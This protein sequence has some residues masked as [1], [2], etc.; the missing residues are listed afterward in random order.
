MIEW[1]C[2]AYSGV[3]LCH[4]RTYSLDAFASA[5]TPKRTPAK[6]ETKEVVL[7]PLKTPPRTLTSEERIDTNQ[8][9]KLTH[10]LLH[11][12]FSATGDLRMQAFVTGSTA[13]HRWRYADEAWKTRGHPHD[14]DVAVVA[15]VPPP[16]DVKTI[17]DP[18]LVITEFAR[19]TKLACDGAG[20][21]LKLTQ[22][23]KR[24]SRFIQCKA[25]CKLPAEHR[26]LKTHGDRWSFMLLS[27]PEPRSGG[28]DALLHYLEPQ[29]LHVAY[30]SK[31]LRASSRCPILSVA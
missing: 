2:C 20:G 13:L 6:D 31:I 15:M 21:E 7:A 5:L 10:E 24:R 25:V 3:C 23:L 1:W 16:L 19:R 4:V 9:L 17:A 22:Y 12:C 26:F 18:A 8:R 29:F 28:T 11:R 30:G 27:S 14:L